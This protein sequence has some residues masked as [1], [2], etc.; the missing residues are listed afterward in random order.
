MLTKLIVQGI[1]TVQSYRRLPII[2]YTFPSPLACTS[3]QFYEG[4]LQP[5]Q[6]A[7]L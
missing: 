5:G 7:Y 4:C 3:D 6:K 2:D 1:S